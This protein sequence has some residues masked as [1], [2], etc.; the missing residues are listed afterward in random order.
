MEYRD[1]YDL[2]RMLKVLN[3]NI[4]VSPELIL[5]DYRVGNNNYFIYI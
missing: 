2:H 3:C 1:I 5:D 4:Q